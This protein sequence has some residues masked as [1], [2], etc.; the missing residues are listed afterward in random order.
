[1]SD[2]HES[3]PVG[4]VEIDQFLWTSG[5]GRIPKS[6]NQLARP[7]DEQVNTTP[8]ELFRVHRCGKTSAQV[9]RGG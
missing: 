5:A 9:S 4:L 8:A 6:T 1:M 3:S 2:P 7:D